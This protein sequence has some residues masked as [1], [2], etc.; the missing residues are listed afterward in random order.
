MY[1]NAVGIA[2]LLQ[3]GAFTL[4]VGLLCSPVCRNHTCSCGMAAPSAATACVGA[5]VTAVL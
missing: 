5:P 2:Y 4:R 1:A 3:V